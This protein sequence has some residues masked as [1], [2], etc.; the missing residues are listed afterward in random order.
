MGWRFP[1]P[2]TIT[3]ADPG[4]RVFAQV[5]F[6]AGRDGAELEPGFA[7]SGPGVKGI[8]LAAEVRLAGGQGRCPGAQFVDGQLLC[9]MTRMV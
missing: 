8:D 7:V 5:L 1:R 4:K 9:G 3:P 6:G 2:G